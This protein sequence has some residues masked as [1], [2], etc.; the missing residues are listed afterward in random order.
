MYVKTRRHQHTCVHAHTGPHSATPELRRVTDT[1]SHDLSVGRHSTQK[2]VESRGQI[3]YCESVDIVQCQSV[4]SDLAFTRYCFTSKLF[5][6]SQRSFHCHP[7][8]SANPTLLQYYCITI[9]QYTPP[10]DPPFYD[11]HYLILVMAISCKGQLATDNSCGRNGEGRCRVEGL[12][13]RLRST[14]YGP[15]SG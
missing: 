10:T 14:L 8:I 2:G 1:T 12:Y 11:I 3:D 4:S 9:A 15:M 7:F 13:T 5:C 6:G